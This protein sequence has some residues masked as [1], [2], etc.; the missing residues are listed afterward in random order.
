MVRRADAKGDADVTG[1]AGGSDAAGAAR[2]T[3]CT[4]AARL[5]EKSCSYTLGTLVPGKQS[6]LWPIATSAP[7]RLLV[8]PRYDF[9]EEL[10]Y[11]FR[12]FG[13]VARRHRRGL[14]LCFRHDPEHDPPPAA[15]RRALRRARRKVF[16]WG[17]KPSCCFVGGAI[18]ER[19]LP[20]LGRA[21]HAVAALPSANE[22]ER[23]AFY[24][25]LGV[26]LVADGAA[27]E[28]AYAA[29]SAPPTGGWE[30]YGEARRVPVQ[31][32][33][34][35]LELCYPHTPGILPYLHGVLAGG[36]YPLLAQPDYQA[37]VI[38]D[39][40]A[41]VGCAALYFATSYPRA[42]VYSFEPAQASYRFLEENCRQLPNIRCFPYGL[43]ERDGTLPL[44]YGATSSMQNSL[45][46]SPDTRAEGETVDLRRASAELRRLG[47]S[48][49]SILKVD[50]EGCELPILRDLGEWLPRTDILY[51]EYH[52]EEDRRALD[53]LLAP[54][55]HLCRARADRVHRGSNVYAARRLIERFPALAEPRLEAP[56]PAR[57]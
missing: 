22:S 57:G 37:R 30:V 2:C 13:S 31:V 25:A 56:S 47:L 3:G 48:E 18:P 16:G 6:D 23:T 7:F 14:A 9:A 53:E 15:A 20:R 44:R 10:E 21:V 46:I 5:V 29:R 52:S 41:H 11:L 17:R 4:L 39:V 40:G 32:N 8:W 45:S 49:V 28:S 12:E 1:D 19:E 33:G 42:A 27:L 43:H 26:D 50:T 34:L 24:L 35:L 51:L 54:H 55:F 38:V 36:E